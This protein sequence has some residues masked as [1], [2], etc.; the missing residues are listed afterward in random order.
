M[1][2]ELIL[3]WRCSEKALFSPLHSSDLTFVGIYHDWKQVEKNVV[4]IRM[5]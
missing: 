4:I 5:V 3:L 1:Q 2:M